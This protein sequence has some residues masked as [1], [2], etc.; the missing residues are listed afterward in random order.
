L[1]IG[2]CDNRP[3][4]KFDP[5]VTAKSRAAIDQGKVLT[6][7]EFARELGRSAD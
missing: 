6:L 2:S 4:P 3:W 1:A 7:E 5:A